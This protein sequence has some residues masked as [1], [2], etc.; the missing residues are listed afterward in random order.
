MYTSKV[1]DMFKEMESMEKEW[2]WGMYG[3]EITR[4]SL[5]QK[6][7]HVEMIDPGKGLDG[8]YRCYSLPAEYVKSYISK[9]AIRIVFTPADYEACWRS[10][11][12]TYFK[13]EVLLS[14][15]LDLIKESFDFDFDMARDEFEAE[16]RARYLIENKNLANGREIQANI[17]LWEGE[18]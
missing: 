4:A 7:V 14:S 16:K 12:V 10:G 11:E 15:S 13:A 9:N 2:I 17:S 6:R 1:K 18:Y 3:S 8:Y 5:G